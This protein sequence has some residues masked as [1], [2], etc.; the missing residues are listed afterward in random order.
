MARARRV[1]SS[2]RRALTALALL[3]PAAALNAATAAAPRGAAGADDATVD[4][5]VQLSLPALA[6]A[7]AAE[8]AAARQRIAQQQDAVMA[9]LRELGATEQGRVQTVRNALAVRL[10]RAAL[11]QARRIDGVRRITPV[12]H[13]GLHRP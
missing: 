3:A 13:P 12:R 9:A 6:S 11:E 8:R 2:T 1:P 7:P 4:V 10:P 5:W